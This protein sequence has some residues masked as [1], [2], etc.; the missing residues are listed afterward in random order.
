MPKNMFGI[1]WEANM[2]LGNVWDAYK[3][4]EPLGEFGDTASRVPSSATHGSAARWLALQRRFRCGCGKHA[5]QSAGAGN[6]ALGEL[7]VEVDATGSPARPMSILCVGRSRCEHEKS[8]TCLMAAV[9]A[10]GGPSLPP[11]RLRRSSPLS[12]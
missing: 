3:L 2:P 4:A 6:R 11:A 9:G 8:L 12:A 7:P 1:V 10:G 5:G